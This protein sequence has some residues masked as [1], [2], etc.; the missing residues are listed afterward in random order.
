MPIAWIRGGTL[1][2]Y[3]HWQTPGAGMSGGGAGQPGCGAAGR[4]SPD[5]GRG[6]ARDC[7][8]G[9]WACPFGGSGVGHVR[10]RG[11]GGRSKE[12]RRWQVK[13]LRVKQRTPGPTITVRPGVRVNSAARCFGASLRR[14][15][16]RGL[17][18]GVAAFVAGDGLARVGVDDGARLAD[19]ARAAAAGGGQDQGR[20]ESDDSDH[21]EDV[22]D[23]GLVDVGDQA[24][25]D[26]PRQD[27]A[28]GERKMEE[29]ILMTCSLLSGGT[30][31]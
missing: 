5:A 3:V 15:G 24:G 12:V 9:G 8:A 25:R 14:G 19:A 11:C 6:I 29:P 13:Q 4:G 27:G 20:D 16:A 26:G 7:R 18:A 28:D 21:H 31:R 23:H 30:D 2:V 1:R 10:V 22:A 17:D